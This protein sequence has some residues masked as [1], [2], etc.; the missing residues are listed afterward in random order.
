MLGLQAEA[1]AYHRPDLQSQ[2]G[3]YF[4]G[5]RAA[6]VAG[7]LIPAGDYVQAQRV[8]RVGQRK[9]AALFADVDLIVTPTASAGAPSYADLSFEG[10]LDPLHTPYWN[11]LGNPAMS[12]PMGFT[13][14]GLPIGLQIIGKPF[15]EAAV[16]AAGYAYQQQ[17]DWHLKVPQIV[18][19]Y[20]A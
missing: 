1:Y 5:T 18:S 11:A 17:T 20:F 15:D 12:V 6:V 9:V 14:D 19:D 16:L 13:D 10:L 4:A 8:R 2:W 7:A 3:N